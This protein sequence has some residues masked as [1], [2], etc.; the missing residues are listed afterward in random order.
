[1]DKLNVL[2]IL[3]TDR[4]NSMS[5]KAWRAVEKELRSRDD[6]ELKLADP[7]ELQ[8][9]YN[10]KNPLYNEMA[11]W[12]DA[13]FIVS[14]EYNHGY[15]GTLKTLFDSDLENYFHKAVAFAG[16]SDGPN[17]GARVIEQLV[18]VVK[19][20]KLSPIRY[21]VNF[22]EAPRL[23]DAEGNLTD[24]KIKEYIHST[25]DELL[26]VAKALKWGRE[27]L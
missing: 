2:L 21:D 26:W 5:S 20:A 22:R 13:Y 14:P 8:V 10:K 24:D 23:F 9:T 1:M 16:V 27:N 6:L 18:G 3:G 19:P 7:R 17:G 4:E 11:A 15:P 25:T 12:A